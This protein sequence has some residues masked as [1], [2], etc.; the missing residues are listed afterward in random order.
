MVLDKTSKY[1]YRYI[2]TH[3]Y[4]LFVHC[5]CFMQTPSCIDRMFSY[6]QEIH[7]SIHIICGCKCHGLTYTSVQ[8][9]NV[10]TYN[11]VTRNFVFPSTYFTRRMER[12]LGG[13]G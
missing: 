1:V 9:I 6:P 4:T 2:C 13:R 11:I 7:I 3:V 12:I 8:A 5:G 10:C